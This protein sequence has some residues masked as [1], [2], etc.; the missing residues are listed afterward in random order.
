MTRRRPMP[1]AMEP[2]PMLFCLLALLVL[3]G[4]V[5]N[6]VP[7]PGTQTNAPPSE[8]DDG[9]QRAKDAGNRGLD[10]RRTDA[11]TGSASDDALAPAGAVTDTD[12]SDDASDGGDESGAR[13]DG[14]A[15]QD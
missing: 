5:V 13:V 10:G 11:A 3:A 14:T 7:T 6:P 4:C 12:A 1:R 9:D 8:A 15:G 2:Q